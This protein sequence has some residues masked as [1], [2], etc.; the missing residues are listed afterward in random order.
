MKSDLHIFSL[1]KNGYTQFFL[2]RHALFSFNVNNRPTTAMALPVP[3][4]SPLSHDNRL[5]V[6][7]RTGL[8]HFDM[9]FPNVPGYVIPE[10]VSP[11]SAATHA[12]FAA[13]GRPLKKCRLPVI[14]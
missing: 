6:G 8:V 7:N 13:L 14:P 10:M 5:Q 12:S 9:E 4:W 2:M 3:L 1:K 11:A